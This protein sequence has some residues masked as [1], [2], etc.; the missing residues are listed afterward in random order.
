[1]E[2]NIRSSDTFFKTIS[3]SDFDGETMIAVS[4]AILRNSYSNEEYEN[5]FFTVFILID[6]ECGDIVLD[7]FGEFNTASERHAIVKSTIKNTMSIINNALVRHES[8]SNGRLYEK[9]INYVATSY[10]DNFLWSLQEFKKYFE[11]AER[12]SF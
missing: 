11:I 5:E 4:R 9:E 7:G 3:L 1:M 2:D 8:R 6:E 10:R 12:S